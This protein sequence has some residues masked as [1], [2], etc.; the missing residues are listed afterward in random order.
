MHMSIMFMPRAFR[1]CSRA[2][3]HVI[4]DTP[5]ALRVQHKQET[6]SSWTKQL[7]RQP[8]SLAAEATQ[9]GPA[10]QAIKYTSGQ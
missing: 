5:V 8:R 3:L 2:Q 10:L 1:E 9:Q 6:E 7:L 4:T